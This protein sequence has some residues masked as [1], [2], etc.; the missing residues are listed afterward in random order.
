MILYEKHMRKQR[1]GKE[2]DD[3]N[4]IP[5]R[6]GANMAS[7]VDVAD[8][9]HVVIVGGGFGG[10][11]AARGL[12]RAPVRVTVIDRSNHHLFQPLLYEVATA[13]LSPADISA[14]IRHVLRRQRNTEVILGEV[15]SVDVTGQRVLVADRSVPYDY[16]VIATGA[17]HSYFGHDDWERFAPGLKAIPDATAIRRKVLL[18]FERA[19][20]EPDPQVRSALLTFVIVGAG[21]TGV[22]MA[23][24]IAELAHKTLVADFRHIDPRSTRILLVEAAP[25]ILAAFPEQ[26]ARQAHRKLERLGV[27]VRTGQA[28]DEVDAEGVTIAGVRVAASTVIWAAGVRASPAGEWLGAKVDRA[29]RVLVQPDLTVEGHPEIYVIGDTAA[30]SQDGQPL[31]GMAPV[32]MQQ[33]RYVARAIRRRVRGEQAAPPFHYL[34][35]G[36]LATVGRAFAIAH[37]WKLELSGLFAWLVWVAVHIWYLIGFRN[38]LLVLV[39]WAWAYL[40]HQQGARLIVPSSTVPV[41][42]PEP[43][44]LATGGEE[45]AVASSRHEWRG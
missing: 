37:I 1:S 8:V 11:M 3:V 38:R 42:A 25:R 12:G 4:G 6:I 31:P 23:G 30:L 17:R 2:G 45:A 20:L 43:G 39:Q 7:A 14:P 28:V 27:T 21:P 40:T 9:P 26:L 33:G 41:A 13:G 24:A 22:E 34:D 32:A 36:S 29:G 15:T 19:E 5:D 16:L 35:K 44:R 10:L 18:A